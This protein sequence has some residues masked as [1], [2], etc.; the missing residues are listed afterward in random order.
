MKSTL[1]ALRR[2]HVVAVCHQT[3]PE[4]F[5]AS[6]R[7]IAQ[8]HGTALRGVM[9]CNSASHA[10]SS[11]GP[12]FDTVRG[13]NAI[14]DF[15][16]Y[17]EGLERLLAA[18]ADA[19]SGSVLFVNDTLL[20][21]HASDCILGRLLA[22][23]GLLQQMRV[24][25]IAGKLDP[26]RSVCL[27]NPWSGHDSYISSFCFLL[28]VH[29]LPAMRRLIDD[30]ASDGVLLDRPIE[31]EAWGQGVPVLLREHI[32]AH[33]AYEGSPYLWPLASRKDA[34]LLRKKACCVYFE[35]RLSGAI[36]QDGAI[37]P[38]N[39]GPRSSADIFVREAFARAARSLKLA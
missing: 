5:V 21:K 28:N 4:Q 32:R 3:P 38:I 16:G 2:I 29:A 15:S 26:Y 24:P 23:D 17:F 19:A 6:L 30:A 14:L 13:S 34:D 20:T 33:L 27:R 22:L 7:R 18:H 31:D 9:V 35:N 10:L 37:V 12:D 8:R 11:E 39:S 36:G 25:A 1:P